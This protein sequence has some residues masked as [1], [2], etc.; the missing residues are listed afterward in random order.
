M[1]TI[2][3]G[4]KVRDTVSGWVGIITARYEY[5]NGC[6]R[7]EVSGADKDGKPESFVFDAQQIEVLS[8]PELN[9]Q[10]QPQVQLRTGGPRDNRPVAR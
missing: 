7:Y 4:A 8:A 3:L 6:E 9:L 10:R 2:E 5:L 1:H